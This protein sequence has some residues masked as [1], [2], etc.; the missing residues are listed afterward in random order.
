MRKKHAIAA[1]LVMSAMSVY[2]ARAIGGE[3]AGSAIRV[4][5]ADHV[6]LSTSAADV[7]PTTAPSIKQNTDGTFSLTI[8]RDADLIDTLR[9]IGCQAQKS[10]IPSKAVS[11]TLP[12][13]DLYNVTIHEALDA[14]L[15]PNGFI[16][17]EDGNFIYV[18][19]AKEMD[20]MLKARRVL[21][22]DPYVTTDPNHFLHAGRQRH[23]DD[24]ARAKPRR[25]GRDH[26][27]RRDGR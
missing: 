23:H 15:K 9:L 17:K 14:I 25:P 26:Q 13:L 24:Q 1:A 6:D 3:S 8:T 4:V 12:A 22:T 27:S 10:I 18:Y 5:S 19:S 16:Y 2:S 21:M 7:A 20:D 11:G